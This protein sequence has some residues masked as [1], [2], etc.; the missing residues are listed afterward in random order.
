MPIEHIFQGHWGQ[1][2]VSCRKHMFWIAEILCRFSRVVHNMHSRSFLSFACHIWWNFSSNRVHAKN[3]VINSRYFSI[4]FFFISCRKKNP[5]NFF[6]S[7]KMEKKYFLLGNGKF[8]EKKNKK[9]YIASFFW[10]LFWDIFR[11]T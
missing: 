11:W 2:H 8:Q 10:D 1:I 5:P 7:R 4:F 9:K 3:I 6:L